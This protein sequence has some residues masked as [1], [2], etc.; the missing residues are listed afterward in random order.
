MNANPMYAGLPPT[1]RATIEAWRD[2]LKATLGDDLVAIL[3]T[4]GVA[5]GDYR[6]GDS[7]ITAIVVV[8]DATF[9]KL[10]AISPAT[11]EARWRQCSRPST[12]A[13][14]C[15]RVSTIDI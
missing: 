3:L 5:R 1:V 2:A 12:V 14:S 7:D 6:P 8:N 10:D 13:T 4:G 15:S 9:A 11:Q